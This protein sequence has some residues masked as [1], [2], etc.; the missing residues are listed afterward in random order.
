MALCAPLIAAGGLADLGIQEEVCYGQ[1]PVVPDLKQFRRRSTSLTLTK[2]SYSSE[3]IRSDRMVSDARHGVRRAGGDIVVE[4]SPGSHEMAWE[5]L[6]GGLWVTPATVTMPA[7]VAT[8]TIA[9]AAGTTDQMTLTR[10]TGSFITDK[11]RVGDTVRF[12]GTAHPNLNGRPLTVNA[13]TALA[14][15]V[16]MPNGASVGVLPL[17]AS[18]G[19]LT[20]G[21][22]R[23]EM[24][25]I[26]RSFTAER[27]FTDIGSFIT[28]RG[29]RF[30]TAAVDLPATGIA[31]ATFGVMGQNADPISG[32]SY[33]GVAQVI[34]TDAAHG[35]LTFAAAAGTIT[36]ATGSW[37]TDGF[38]IGD[39]ILIDGA[40]LNTIPQNRNLRTV[41]AVSALVLTVAEAI[42]SGASAGAYTVTRV[43]APAYLAAPNK[44][45]LVAVAGVLM[46]NGVPV[47]TVTAASF[48]V[49]NQIDGSPV[50]GS[51]V[52]PQN[53]F[54]TQCVITGNLTVLFDRGGAGAAVYNAF[55][56]EQ[57]ASL[58]MR[59]DSADGL[60]WMSFFFPRIKVNSG[61]IGDAVST[62]LPVTVAWAA[63]KPT[64]GTITSQIVVQDSS[65]TGV[66]A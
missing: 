14:L 39:K 2:D 52:V 13:V 17:T 53:M 10:A 63:L 51:N 66:A 18:T 60:D 41:I 31:T 5:A 44:P 43:G 50:V 28:Y 8:V 9:L 47:A 34:T 24:G 61:D 45:V 33:D 57:D 7:P 64:S 36:G 3:E 15:T 29:L 21:G 62:G 22:A 12:T 20:L 40:G 49:D 4:L 35:V 59:F 54:G 32:A 27:A 55:D 1:L 23:S 16:Q 11:Y 65:V 6:L 42:Q 56:L 25:N 26:G 30:N 37:I 38:A 48:N 46:L 58:M 19:T